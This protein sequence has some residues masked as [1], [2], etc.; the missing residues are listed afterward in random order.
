MQ[1]QQPAAAPGSFQKLG[2]VAI[3]SPHTLALQPSAAGIDPAPGAAS[4]ALPAAVDG[5]VNTEAV[6]ESC[7]IYSLWVPGLHF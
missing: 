2:V 3:L 4:E 7:W 5:G 6:P 1:R